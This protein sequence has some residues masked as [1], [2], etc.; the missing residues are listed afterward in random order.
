MSIEKQI[1]K[2]ILEQSTN[3]DFMCGK[4]IM[5]TSIR[6]IIKGADTIKAIKV[7]LEMLIDGSIE[8]SLHPLDAIEFR[9]SD[10]T[11]DGRTRLDTLSKDS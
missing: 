7:F 9:I 5:A 2:H 11:P 1:R 4:S 10:I 3:I 8:G 6:D